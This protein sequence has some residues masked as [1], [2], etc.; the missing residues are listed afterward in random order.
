MKSKFVT[1]IVNGKMSAWTGPNPDKD[2]TA[3]Q[4]AKDLSDRFSEEGKN[5]LPVIVEEIRPQGR[6]RLDNRKRKVVSAYL[7]EDIL[8]ALKKKAEA[9][10][11]ASISA[12]I[13]AII[14]SAVRRYEEYETEPE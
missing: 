10:G 7:P 4:Q 6:P 8:E 14:E 9:N 11:G 3:I 12:E 13:S 2:P 1:V 5:S